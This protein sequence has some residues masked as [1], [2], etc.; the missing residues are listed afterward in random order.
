VK[1]IL[2]NLFDGDE[3][4]KEENHWGNWN[5]R[6]QYSIGFVEEVRDILDEQKDED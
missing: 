3:A 1:D 2:D 5:R 4:A 6:K